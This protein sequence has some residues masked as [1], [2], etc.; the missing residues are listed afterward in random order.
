MD[1]HL[2]DI[3]KKQIDGRSFKDALSEG[4]FMY[5]KKGEKVNKIRHIRI[6]VRDK[7]PLRI[8]EQ[9]NIS[10]KALV[11][12]D[13]RN[14]KHFYYAGNGENYAY[15]L[16]HGIVK[17]KIERDYRIV[18][19]FDAASLLRISD[20]RELA[21]EPEIAY[22]KKGDTLQFYATLKIGHKVLFF[23]E[24]PDELKDFLHNELSKR[25][26]KILGFEK[27]GRIRFMHHLESRDDKQLKELEPRYGKGIWQGFSA[28]NFE[29]PWPKLKLSI[30]NF[31][32]L[33]EGKDF[34]VKPDGAII[35][36]IRNS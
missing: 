30:S 7:E 32:F 33:I 1:N 2:L 35:L 16:Y 26:Y 19:L 6:F 24:N 18:N 28:V 25:L 31:N 4:I 22:N 10:Q 20:N 3:I 34:E 23:K 17:N 27:D 13:N 5:N 12:L 21:I 9:L 11:N 15:A 14:H 36:R 8:K 29:I